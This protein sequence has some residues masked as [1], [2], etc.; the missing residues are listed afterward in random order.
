MRRGRWWGGITVLTVA[1]LGGQAAWPAVTDEVAVTFREVARAFG[2]AFPAVEGVVVAVDGARVTLDL[3]EPGKVF[4]GMELRVVRRGESFRHPVTGVILGRY[5][6]V[7]GSAQVEKAEGAFL[8]ARFVSRPQASPV[9]VE[10]LVRIT[11]GRILVAVAPILDLTQS[12]LDVKRI[13][14]LLAAALE[15]TGRFAPA[16][17]QAVAELMERE[18]VRT[19]DLLSRPALAV[20]LTQKLEVDGWVIPLLAEIGDGTMVDATWVSAVTGTPL[21]SRRHPL[22]PAPS[23]LRQRFPWE[24]PAR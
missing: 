4:R 20:Q 23:Q 3:K 10:D 17:P 2:D 22:I 8:T 13:P 1:L 21:F 9:R 19:V 24:P 6:E 7:L 15:R 5:E 14:Y 18:R 12:R 11:R 16:D